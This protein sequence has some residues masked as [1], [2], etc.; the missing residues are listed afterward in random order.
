VVR[1]ALKRANRWLL[2]RWSLAFHVALLVPFALVMVPM[3]LSIRYGSVDDSILF[4][5]GVLALYS[6]P[7]IWIF[8]PG[9]YWLLERK[10]RRSLL[11]YVGAAALASLLGSLIFPPAI[12]FAVPIGAAIGAAIWCAL[13]IGRRPLQASAG[14]RWQLKSRFKSE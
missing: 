2:L 11:A 10:R 12:P 7:A 5:I 13:W 8:L 14:H 4:V 9:I 6:I 3:S 1:F